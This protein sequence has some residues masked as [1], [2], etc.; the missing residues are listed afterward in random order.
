[1]RLTA[2]MP[3]KM[4]QAKFPL[5]RNGL[6]GRAVPW[7]FIYGFFLV[8]MALFGSLGFLLFYGD[9][10]QANYSGDMNERTFKILVS[11]LPI[12]VYIVFYIAIFGIDTIKWLIMNSV[13]GVLGIYSQLG[14]ILEQFGK[15]LSDY[16]I[17][18]HIVPGIYYV[19]YTFLLRRAVL[20]FLRA[21]DGTR[22][23]TIIDILYVV[24]SVVFYLW[25]L[26]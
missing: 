15:S 5:N 3:K 16:P 17:W 24:I 1:M 13:I 20:H 7:V 11:T 2:P 25:L 18:A 4:Y 22:K 6:R 26:Q 9:P 10:S 21:Q 19:L 14:W 12:L 23:K 8:H